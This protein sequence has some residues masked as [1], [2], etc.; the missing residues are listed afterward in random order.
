[1]L[2]SLHKYEPRVHVV[3]VPGTNGDKQQMW[4]YPF[5]STQFVAVTAYQNEDVTALKIKHNPFAKAFLDAKERPGVGSPATACNPT[6][7]GLP[8]W[9]MDS[10][11]SRSRYT[12]YT[13]HHRPSYIKEESVPL[14]HYDNPYYSMYNPALTPAGYNCTAPPASSPG[15]CSNSS[16]SSHPSPTPEPIPGYEYQY[17]HPHQYYPEEFFSPLSQFDYGYNNSLLLS[18]SQ[19]SS[20]P[21]Y[22]T[23]LLTSSTPPGSS[24]PHHHQLESAAKCKLEPVEPLSLEPADWFT[25]SYGQQHRGPVTSVAATVS[26]HTDLLPVGGGVGQSVLPSPASVHHAILS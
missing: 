13:L 19:A 25:A 3:R 9:Y 26:S 6:N 12:P 2:N 24:H 14:T 15:N 1:M 16:S 5:P 7:A 20:C 18:T 21:D 17:Q 4:T 11:R 22:T 10:S 23:G 8:N